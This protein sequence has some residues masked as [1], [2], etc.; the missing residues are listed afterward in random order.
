MH[1]VKHDIKLYFAISKTRLTNNSQQVC[2]VVHALWV[3]CLEQAVLQTSNT[4]AC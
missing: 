4:E 2:I 3:Q 1:T